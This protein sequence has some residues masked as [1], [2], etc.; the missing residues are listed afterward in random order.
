MPRVRA[1]EQYDKNFDHLLKGAAKVFYEKGYGQASLRDIARATRMSLAG[2]YYYVS[3]KEELLFQIQKHCFEEVLKS[4]RSRL[5]GVE[6][7]QQR[8]RVLIENHL[9]FFVGNMEAMKVLSHEGDTLSGGYQRE[10]AVLKREYVRMARSIVNE[11]LKGERVRGIDPG[12]AALCLFGMMNW[13]YNW[14]DAKRDGNAKELSKTV[15]RIFAR[16]VISS[17]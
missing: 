9:H 6:D 8:L 10:I 3:S 2:I 1:Q 17:R 7:P 16:G 14:Y 12:T 4:L 11:V 5:V 15:E 13:I